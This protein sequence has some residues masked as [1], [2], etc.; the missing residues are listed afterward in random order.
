MRGLINIVCACVPVPTIRRNMRKKLHAAWHKHKNNLGKFRGYM[1]GKPIIVWF[2]HALGGGT[3]VYSKRQFKQL[4]DEY[5]VLRIQ[6]VPATKLYHLTRAENH[7]QLFTTDTPDEIMEFLCTLNIREIVVNNMVAYRDTL[8]TLD[9]IDAI[10]NG[11]KIRPR[12]SYRG[13]DYHAICPSFNLINCDGKYCQLNYPGGCEKCWKHKVMAPNPISDCILK[14]GAKTIGQWRHRWGKFLDQT[15][16][17][18][19]V[20]S[21]FGAEI[22]R[23]AYPSI[24]HKIAV[25]P[26][27]VHQYRTAKIKPHNGINIVVLGTM[28]HQKGAD[29]IRDM[30][31]YLNLYPNVKITIIG[32]MKKPPQNIRVHGKYTAKNLVRIM[33]KYMA[34]I[35]LIPSI[36]P[37]TFSY[38][39]SEAMSMGLPVA[40]FDMGA[41]AERVCKYKYGLVL[42]DVAPQKN[43]QQIIE[44]IQGLKK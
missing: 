28:S 32:D 8:K 9:V 3:E 44:F 33:E 7:R 39:T 29:V 34:D 17:E 4:G 31:G 26:H 23:R 30:A 12:V 13:H 40:C 41:P 37:E 25:I 14:S 38:T 42:S 21:D 1:N 2:D 35:V 20:F 6:Y 10:C 19:I 22:L 43:L 24:S 5:D 15:V 16:D 27:T 11:C 18:I 36:W